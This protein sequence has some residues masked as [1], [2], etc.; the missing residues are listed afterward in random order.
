VRIYSVL[1]STK[2]DKMDKMVTDRGLPVLQD[3]ADKQFEDAYSATQSQAFIFFDRQGCLVWNTI[4]TGPKIM[5]DRK[6][7]RDHLATIGG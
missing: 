3:S 5:I 1:E 7:I 2:R 6:A 4:M